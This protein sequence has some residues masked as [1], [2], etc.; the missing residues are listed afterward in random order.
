[1]TFK[2]LDC[3]LR[4]GS[5]SIDYQFGRELTARVLAGLEMS[6]I[7]W[8]EMGHGLGLG[9]NRSCRKVA[10][11]SD[12]EYMELAA[13]TLVDAHY[14]FMFLKKIGNREDLKLAADKG[15]DFVRI[16]ANIT[17][18]DEIEECVKDAKDLGLTVFVALMKAYAL[19]DT[20]AYVS[21]LQKLEA[22]GV[23]LATVMD[24]AGYMTP[25]MAAE[26]ITTAKNNSSV[27]MGFHAHNNLQ[28]AVANTIAAIRAGADVV[29]VSIG[30]L[31]RS[32][33]NTPSEVM[34]LLLRRYGWGDD[35]DYK[36]L[37][38]LNDECIFPLIKGENRFCSK[39]LTFGF[40]GFHSGFYDVITKAV[41]KYPNIDY[42]D[43]VVSVSSKEKINVTE[44]LVEEVAEDLSRQ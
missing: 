17:E 5:H 35:V 23:S 3:T 37:S 28:L 6:G 13:E 32:S 18:V 12:E 21:I 11:L 41:S 10:P 36:V 14:G 40:A 8:I 39:N 24:S 19:T 25:E 4:D 16:G 29:D 26:Y 1:M 9:A 34:A 2:I 33:G 44:D 43:L 20:A 15:V 30:G 31:G 38:D 7:R 22:W 27:K 42:R